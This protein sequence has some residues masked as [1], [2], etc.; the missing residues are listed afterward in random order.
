MRVFGYAADED[1]ARLAAAGA[2]TFTDMA[3]LRALIQ[4]HP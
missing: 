1:V 2:F 3:E 4:T